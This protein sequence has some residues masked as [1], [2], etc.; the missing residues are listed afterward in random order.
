[1]NKRELDSIVN[2]S[3]R[4]MRMEDYVAN[5]GGKFVFNQQTGWTYEAPQVIK[6]VVEKVA[7]RVEKKEKEVKS[8]LFRKNKIK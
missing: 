7:K 4:T 6:N 2:D 1:M 5:H 3:R 8:K